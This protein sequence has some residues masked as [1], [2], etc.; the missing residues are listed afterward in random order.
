MACSLSV[1]PLASFACWRGRSTAGSSHYR[2]LRAV[3]REL[4]YPPS[5][6]LGWFTEAADPQMAL[7]A[8]AE[9]PRVLRLHT[10]LKIALPGLEEDQR[11]EAGL[12][13]HRLWRDGLHRPSDRRI[14]GDVLS[15]RRCSVLGNRGT[16]DP[17]T[18]ED[19]C[20]HRRTR[21]FAFGE[22]GCRRAGQ[23]AFDVRAQGRD[24]HH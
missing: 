2:T 21:R 10:D 22:G 1:A 17:Q 20:R 12:R 23:P 24:H 9:R 7:A 11:R 14:S 6:A 16:L 3:R 8:R 13:P 15:R 18:P 4:L 5:T 19:A